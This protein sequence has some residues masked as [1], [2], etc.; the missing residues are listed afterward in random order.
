MD[1][2]LF[3]LPMKGPYIVFGIQWLQKL[4]KVT[5]DYS[6]QIMEFT[7]LDRV[8]ALKG[9]DALRMK[10]ISLHHMHALLESEDIYGVYKLYN[11]DYNAGGK[12]TIIKALALVHPEIEHL[13]EEFDTIF[14]VPSTLPLHRSIDHRIHLFPNTKPVNVRSY[15]FPHYQKGE[16]KKLV[17]EMLSKG[18]IRVSYSPFS[19]P[20]L[21]VKKKDR[22]CRFCVD[23]RALNEVT[24]KDKFLISTADEMFDELGDAVIFTKFDLWAGY[25]QIRVMIGMCTKQPSDHKFYVKKTKYVFRAAMLE[26]LSFK[27]G[28]PEDAAFSAL[29]DWLIHAPILC[30]IDFEDTFVNEA[31]ALLWASGG[32]LQPMP[33]PIS[34]WEDVSMDFIMGFPVFKGLTVILVVVDH[35][36]EYA[37]F[38]TLPTTFNAS[39]VAE[40]FMDMVVKHHGFPKTIVSD[41]DPIFV[42]AIDELLV[43]RNVLLRQLKEN[44]FATRNRMEMQAN[45]S[46]REVEFNV[47]DKEVVPLLS[48]NRHQERTGAPNVVV[49]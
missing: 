41:R 22:S 26:Y 31:D 7:W 12:D 37:H 6:T 14:Q 4:G 19:S 38:G 16:M 11:L 36:T 20:V 13:L 32:L 48:E 24:V 3:V 46:W 10:R 9:D 8:Y 47:G 18:T 17:N 29:K 39:K 34:A 43:E 35:F 30:L 45:R 5:H 40:L 33:I 25:H 42:A 49:F 1:V 27:W 21:L 28:G 15:R 2:D 23:Y 44:L